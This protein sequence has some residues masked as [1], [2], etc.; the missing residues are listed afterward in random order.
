M[1]NNVNIVDIIP[2][3]LLL[4][5]ELILLVMVDN[6]IMLTHRNLSCFIEDNKD[7]IA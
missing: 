1:V 5:F 7:T 2:Y 3:E 4:Q 6:N